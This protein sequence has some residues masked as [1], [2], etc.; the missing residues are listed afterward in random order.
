MGDGNISLQSVLE[1]V[2]RI[3][4]Q[5]SRENLEHCLVSTLIE[6]SGVVFVGIARPLHRS[7]GTQIECLASAERGRGVLPEAPCA[8]I[9][10]QPLMARALATGTEVIDTLPNGRE[11]RCLPVMEGD[12]TA[13]F[14]LVESDDGLQS[15]M[16]VVRAFVAVYRN[17]LA[18]LRDSER[19]TLTGLKNRK[20]FDNNINRVIAQTRAANSA[21]EDRRQREDDEHHWLGIV[22]ID[23][24]KR[25]NDT[26]GHVFG[27]EVLLLF[28]AL[29]RKVFRAEDQL[30]RFGGE[31]FVVVL[32]P[33]TAERARQAFERLRAAVEG[34]AFPQVGQV[35]ASVG[36][37]RIEPDDIPSKVVGQADEALYWGKR[38]GRNRVCLYDDLIAVGELVPHDRE[39]GME[40]F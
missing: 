31:E 25:V 30:F 37:V 39:G 6:L 29:M 10:D 15:S 40:L 22:D 36:F 11:C 26:H 5:R 18:L 19:D 27:D 28:A 23:H 17:Y 9:E 38:N 24:F 32:A 33:T 21:S 34:F 12:D 8:P 14:L 2:V 13:A 4:E 35:T 16:G 7:N 1:S 3:T 20:T